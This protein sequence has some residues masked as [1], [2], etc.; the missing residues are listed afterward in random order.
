MNALQRSIST[1]NHK[2][3]Y[4]LIDNVKH[5]HFLKNI[6]LF[7]SYDRNYFFLKFIIYYIIH[8]LIACGFDTTAANTG[9]YKGAC[10]ILQKLLQRQIFWMA[11]RHQ[12]LEPVVGSAFKHL[13]G[14]MNSP[15]VTLYKMTKSSWEELNL[16]DIVVPDIPTDYMS[17]KE[18]L[19]SFINNMLELK[20]Q[21]RGDEFQ[22]KR[23][24][25][26]HLARWMATSIYTMKMT[27]L[28]YQIPLHLQ[29]KKKGAKDGPICHINL[30]R[31]LQKFKSVDS[32]VST[33]TSAVLNRHAW[34]LTEELIPLSLFNEDLP[35]SVRTILATKIGQITFAET[36]I[37]NPTPVNKKSELSDFVGE[38]SNVLFKFLE[39]PVTFLQNSY[40][41]LM[42]E[43]DAVKKNISNLCPLNDSCERAL[44]LATRFNT[45]ITRKEAGVRGADTSCRSSL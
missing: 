28:L 33:I 12:I 27:L 5:T 41:H 13:F 14:E 30:F 1:L 31:S 20:K 43:Y 11:C 39:I 42:P 4:L 17:D 16:Q 35:L 19:L 40:W 7:S 26:D 21:P 34:Y 9:L 29:K 15:E 36:E 3:S 37:R 6:I 44:G 2:T 45:K 22:I 23:P 10:T 18:D 38:R 8:I 32:K 24:G 25:A